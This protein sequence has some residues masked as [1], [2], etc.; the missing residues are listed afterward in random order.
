MLEA[1]EKW[2][3][4]WCDKQRRDL[5]KVRNR[6]YAAEELFSERFGSRPVVR[7]TILAPRGLNKDAEIA[8]TLDTMSYDG[9][10]HRDLRT[11]AFKSLLHDALRDLKLH[12]EDGPERFNQEMLDC[13]HLVSIHDRLVHHYHESTQA[14]SVARLREIIERRRTEVRA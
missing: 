1:W 13:E 11:E 14:D 12:V 8:L 6:I 5:Q 9:G 2:L 4:D 7:L 10:L 3:T